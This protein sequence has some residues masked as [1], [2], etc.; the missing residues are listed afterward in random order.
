M[1][2]W[3]LAFY[4]AY[5]LLVA[6]L[7]PAWMFA[8]LGVVCF[9]RYTN[10]WHEALHGLQDHAWAWHPAR[11]LLVVVS[12]LSLGRA[13]L[14]ELHRTHH[15]EEGGEGDPDL[16]MMR[17]GPLRAALW[18]LVQPELLTAWSLR[19]R[20][21]GPRSAA[22]MLAY[23]LVWAGLMWLGGWR[24]FIAYN[25]VVRLANGLSWFVF[26]WVVHQPWL[27]GHVLPRPFPRPLRW[28]WVALVG[29]ENYLGV[30][31]HRVHH[32]YP[33]VPD[34][35]LPHLARRLGAA[36]PGA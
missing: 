25:L 32:M 17:P 14:E 5:A 21:L 2:G 22:T 35:D 1:L 30:R 7:L 20:G 34:R 10:R 27:F 12:P 8:A 36:T 11:A 31:F 29:R 18:C 19:R 33:S 24:G 4:G 6:A 28:L 15:R 9:L 26:S 16:P 23:A 13:E 3:A